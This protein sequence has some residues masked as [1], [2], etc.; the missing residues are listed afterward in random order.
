MAFSQ[1]PN[2]LRK[3]RE[4]VAA[5]DEGIIPGKLRVTEGVV[6]VHELTAANV[7]GDVADRALSKRRD[8]EPVLGRER[9][10]VTQQRMPFGSLEPLIEEIQELRYGWCCHS[11]LLL[12][13]LRTHFLTRYEESAQPCSILCSVFHSESTTLFW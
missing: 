8:P 10:E 9:F 2:R 12:V 7:P 13:L 4:C 11:L 6:V 5:I 1:P 3:G